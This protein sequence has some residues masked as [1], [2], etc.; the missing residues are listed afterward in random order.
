M[1]RYGGKHSIKNCANMLQS[2]LKRKS[3]RILVALISSSIVVPAVFCAQ[4]ASGLNIPNRPGFWY[5]KSTTV[6]WL[7]RPDLSLIL[8]PS[9]WEANKKLYCIESSVLYNATGIWRAEASEDYRIAAKLI[10]DNKS[11]DDR[12]VQASIAFAMHNHF[13]INQA[14]WKEVVENGFEDID[15]QIIADTANRLWQEARKQTPIR[16]ELKKEYT[17]GQRAGRFTIRVFNPDG[18]VLSGIPVKIRYDED[19]INLESKNVGQKNYVGEVEIRSTKEGV[20][21]PWEAKKTSNVN[22]SILVQGPEPERLYSDTGQDNIRSDEPAWY[23]QDFRMIV[24]TSFQPTLTSKIDHHELQIG[25]RVDSAVT[26]GVATNDAWI[27]GAHIDAQGY[28][29][30][31]SANSVLHMEPR[32]ENE[33]ATEYLERLRSLSNLRQV[34]AAKATFSNSGETVVASAKRAAGNISL[35]DLDKAEPYTVTKDEVGL[36]GT[37]VWIIADTGQSIPGNA[38]LTKDVVYAFGSPETTV[39]H[40]ALVSSDFAPQQ[41][42]VGLGKEIVNE[43]TVKGLPEEYGSFTGNEKYGF[44]ADKKAHIRV[45]WAGAGTENP[46]KTDNNQYMPGAAGEPTVQ[47]PKEDKHHRM[48]ADWEVP[49]VNGIYRIGDGAITLRDIAGSDKSVPGSRKLVDNVHILAK[50]N[51]DSGWYVFVYDFPGSSRAIAYKSAYDNSWSR[52]YVESNPVNRTVSVTTQVSDN[53]VY[54][55]KKFHDNANITG[56]VPKGSYVIFSAYSYKTDKNPAAK[57]LEFSNKQSVSASVNAVKTVAN[58]TTT[59]NEEV[60]PPMRVDIMN[61]QNDVNKKSSITVQSPDITCNH[62]GNVYWKAEVFNAQGKPLATH[63]LGVE[64]ETVQVIH[65]PVDSKPDSKHE[66][67]KPEKTKPEVKPE[68]KPE[69]KPES[70]PEVK[71]DSKHEDPKHEKTKPESKHEDPKPDS[72]HEDPKHEGKPDS[73]HEDPKHEKTKPEVKPKHEE[74][75]ES[76]HEDPK[77]GK[78]PKHEDPKHEKTKPESKHEDP[79]P[80]S[81]HEDPKHEGKPDSKHEDPKHEKSKPDVKPESKPEVK[82]DSKHEDPK[83]EKTKPESKH[84]NPKHEKTKPEVKP[85]HE[86][87]KP[88]EKPGV[89]HE[90]PKHE[91]KPD[92]KH[93]DP[94]H[95]KTKPEVKSKHEEKPESKHEDPKPGKKPKH[96]DPKHEKTKPESKHEDPKH[97]KTKP[98]V[99][100]KHEEKPESKHEDPK[101]D[102]KPKHEDPKPESKHEDPKHEKTKPG[103]KHEDP[104]PDKKPKREDPKHKG[105]KPEVKHGETHSDKKPKHKEKPRVNSDV[106][107][108]EKP[109][110]SATDSKGG[111]SKSNPKPAHTSDKGKISHSNSNKQFDSENDSYDIETSDNNDSVYVVNNQTCDFGNTD[112]SEC[113]VEDILN[114]ENAATSDSSHG[115]QLQGSHEKNN[116][117]A[118]FTTVDTIDTEIDKNANDSNNSKRDDKTINSDNRNNV[119]SVSGGNNSNSGN[120]SAQTSLTPTSLAT[121]GAPA[122]VVMALAFITLTFASGLSLG[123]FVTIIPRH[124]NRSS[125]A[126]HGDVLP[127]RRRFV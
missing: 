11:N 31:G 82:P 44:S 101:P 64:G 68:S 22:I 80:D 74:K 66:D 55:G 35:P 20:S 52:T 65:K 118:D 100:P 61:V 43:I 34:A 17:I 48:I 23:G 26:S 104:K 73:K 19:L 86:D 5:K 115:E 63:V 29:F 124:K 83:H 97:E 67:P 79:K 62:E 125:R 59:S 33:S 87:P 46:T 126:R 99:K 27:K 121:T 4:L 116:A 3:M 112:N 69:V 37:W 57:K 18:E 32:K 84:E 105:T 85:K 72:K 95:E 98:E 42:T 40:K 89:K 51:S 25:E 70:K 96:E 41:Q 8:G 119:H 122:M 9:L 38:K 71:P 106:K 60:M 1:K 88:K 56:D 78:K 90:D 30:V 14:R 91:V 113:T 110:E 107:S 92:F 103:V 28:Y 76:K 54:V 6:E 127:M 21:I 58:E 109:V 117:N 49:A 7:S 2:S 15:T 16:A 12:V 111:E 102:K 114:S 50:K 36:F 81:K 108:E 94:K 47:E 24:D 53:K 120:S 123:R 45:W 93:E 75:P 77:P 39:V 13:D 10:Q